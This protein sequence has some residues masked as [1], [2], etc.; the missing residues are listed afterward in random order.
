MEKYGR[1]GQATDDNIIRRMRFAGWITEATDTH[2][3]CVILLF[4]R[5]SGCTNAPQCYVIRAL[6]VL[7]K[8]KFVTNRGVDAMQSR[9]ESHAS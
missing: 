5:S 4:H 9:S 3:E 6:P 8:K 7:Y 1:A 2:S